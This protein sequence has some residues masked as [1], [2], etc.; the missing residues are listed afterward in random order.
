MT[1]LALAQSLLF[2]PGNRPDRFDKAA[3]SG[4]H[5]IVLDLE[6]AVPL[7]DK[8]AARAAVAAW[9]SG[10]AAAVVRVNGAATPWYEADMAMLSRLPQAG[11]MLAKADADSAA[12]SAR[13]LPDRPLLALVESIAGVRDL[14]R[15][16]ATPG[17][18]RLAFGS[19]DFSAE[20]GISDVGEAMSLV[21]SRFVLESCF[22]G[23]AAPIDGV[24]THVDDA[25]QVFAD[26]RRAQQ[27]GF[28]GKLCIHPRQVDAVHAAFRPEPAEADW[29][30]R[31]LAAIAASDGGAT[32]VDG[33]MVDAPVVEQARRILGKLSLPAR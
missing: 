17:V 14:A 16:A 9:L 32:T 25:G 7:Q 33:K 8:E 20:S 5:A 29:A 2:V 28:G 4:A 15:V 6:D 13:L 22:A 10:G 3:G 27:F 24:T 18:L 11:V 30:Q 26:A 1:A 12:R 21:R 23:I 19:I 31:V